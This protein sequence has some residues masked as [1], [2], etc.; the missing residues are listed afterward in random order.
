[1]LLALFY[2]NWINYLWFEEISCIKISHVKCERWRGQ[3]HCDKEEAILTQMG[4]LD[5]KVTVRAPL[6]LLKRD[7]CKF[8]VNVF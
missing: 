8:F 3:I 6:T 2:S 1:M 7:K 5:S 4:G